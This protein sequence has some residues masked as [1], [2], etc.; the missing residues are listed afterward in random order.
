MIPIDLGNATVRYLEAQD[1]VAYIAMEKNAEIK[2]YVGGPSNRTEQD[3]LSSLRN[4][5]PCTSLLVVADSE[6]N[7]FIGRCGLL[8]KR[9]SLEVELYIL[10]TQTHLRKGIARVVVPFL[11]RLAAANGKVAVAYVDS[12]NQAS[13]KLLERIGA[14]SDGTN[15]DSGYQVNHIRYIFTST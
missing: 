2:Q 5:S 7:T 15:T 3:L 13:L 9:G 11:V 6:T 14:I 12:A 1:H 10:L 8:E 4:Y